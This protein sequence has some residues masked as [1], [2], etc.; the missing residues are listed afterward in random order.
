MSDEDE[1][2]RKRLFPTYYKAKEKAGNAFNAAKGAVSNPGRAVGGAV[3][4]A[5]SYN[6]GA[7]LARGGIWWALLALILYFLDLFVLGFN[8]IDVRRLVD[9]ISAGEFEWIL[10][11]AFSGVV[12]IIYIFWFFITNPSREEAVAFI[13]P[14]AITS[15]LASMS[16]FLNGNTSALLHVVFVWSMTYGLFMKSVDRRQAYLLLTLVLVVDFFIFSILGFFDGLSFFNRLNIPILFII[17]LKYSEPSGL[18]RAFIIALVL[19]YILQVVSTYQDFN[20]FGDT[21]GAAERQSLM[22]SLG[23]AYYNLIGIKQDFEQEADNFINDSIRELS[24]DVYASEIDANSKKDLGISLTN[25]QAS[26]NRYNLN[27]TIYVWADLKGKALYN[28]KPINVIVVCYAET[29]YGNITHGQ[30][31]MED[32]FRLTMGL[33]DQRPLTCTINTRSQRKGTYDVIFN[34]TFNYTSKGYLKTYFI[35]RDRYINLLR[36]EIDVF[37]ALGIGPSERDPKSKTINAPALLGI[38]TIDPP[39]LITQNHSTY[40]I[41]HMGVSLTNNWVG[42]KVNR[43]NDVRIIIPYGLTTTNPNTAIGP[44]EG[45]FNNDNTWGDP[46]EIAY[47]IESTYL[48]EQVQKN[49]V[50]DPFSEKCN[51]YNQGNTVLGNSPFTTKYYK[52]EIDYEYLFKRRVSVS[53]R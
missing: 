32:V 38:G 37:D 40:P 20:D 46:T 13:F 16:G 12:I 34:V 31:N 6:V 5:L 22:E 48:T 30:V 2:L 19:F 47:R 18:R 50:P 41:S 39:T 42:G 25:V 11:A 23:R 52:A 15:L 24:G 26:N 28:D 45:R 44:C 8:G 17:A 35:D 1:K 49:K 3:T 10:R 4:G 43:I 33:Y 51:L 36:E 7:N 29:S 27:D 53:V 9:S 21:L 14:L